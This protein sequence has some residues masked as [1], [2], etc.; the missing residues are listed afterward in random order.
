MMNSSD[1]W[2]G[3]A[4]SWK[5]AGNTAPTGDLARTV[6]SR[7]RR[8]TQ[9]L[10]LIA[11]LETLIVAGIVVFTAT[12]LLRGPNTFEIVY[13]I[14][15]WVVLVVALG[16]AIEN[17]R[18]LWRPDGEST[19]DYLSLCEERARRKLRTAHFVLQLVLVQTIFVLALAGWKAMR[20]GG[21]SGLL[22]DA[23][24]LG[25]AVTAYTG[26]ALWFRGRARRE[27][28]WVADLRRAIANAENGLASEDL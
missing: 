7:Q 25:A 18:G 26:W 14:A 10:W 27:L 17:R 19:A 2:D 6:E 13:L 5:E 3:L 28:V 16:F 11:G 22:A 23:A 9:R 4:A 8:G 12:T 24:L 1:P 15:L 21:V 20:A